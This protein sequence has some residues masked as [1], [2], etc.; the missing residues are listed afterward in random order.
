VTARW[1]YRTSQDWQSASS[2]RRSMPARPRTPEPNSM[3]LLGSGVVPVVVV[4][5]LVVLDWVP[6]TVN[7]SEGIVPTEF[8]EA[9]DGPEFSSQ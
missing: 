7:A 8:S 1:E 2:L 9:E 3:M 5:V 4:L 6:R